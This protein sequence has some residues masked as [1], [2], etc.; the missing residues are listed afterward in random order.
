MPSG[1]SSAIFVSGV[2]DLADASLSYNS[3]KG[4]DEA[5]RLDQLIE[6]SREVWRTRAYGDMWSYMMVA[7]GLVEVAGEFDVKPWDLAAL[8]PIVVEAGGRFTS[9]DGEDGPWHGSA[10][11]TNGVLHDAVLDVVRVSH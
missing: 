6:L 5:D 8:A 2:T 11:A 1:V 9:A 7:E 10:I 4:W 3:L